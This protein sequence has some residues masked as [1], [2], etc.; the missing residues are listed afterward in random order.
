M[1]AITLFFIALCI[2]HVLRSQEFN[3]EVSVNG[4]QF[5]V[6]RVSTKAISKKPYGT[7]F[8][9]NFENYSA[10]VTTILKFQKELKN[11]QILIFL[12]TWCGDSKR[13]VPRFLKILDIANFP[14]KN[15]KI[16]ALDRRKE[17]YKK[18]PTGEEWGLNIQRVPTFIFYKNGKEVNRIIETPNTKLEEDILAILTTDSYVAHKAKSMHFD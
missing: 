12:G 13:E 5:L 17:H 14:N 8:T 6:G 18:S 2:S 7:W 11:Y 15:L 1:R 9:P 16:V 4:T 10:D 3:R